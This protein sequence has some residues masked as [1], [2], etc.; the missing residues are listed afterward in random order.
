MRPHRGGFHA[1]IPIPVPANGI[2]EFFCSHIFLVRNLQLFP[3]SGKLLMD[4]VNHFSQ[5]VNKFFPA[6]D[7][8]LSIF[9]QLQILDVQRLDQL[10][11]KADVL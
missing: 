10:R 1:D 11:T 9:C 2:I 6:A 5:G 4:S 8:F 7:N 3:A